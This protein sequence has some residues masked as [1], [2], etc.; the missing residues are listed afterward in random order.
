MKLSPYA[1]ANQSEK[2]LAPVYHLFGAEP[3]IIEEA[4]SELRQCAK[5]AGFLE[6]EKYHVEPGFNW[7][8]LLVSNQALSL[9]ASKKVIEVRMPTGKPGDKGGKAL[10]AYCDSLSPDNVL[11]LISGPIE[12][13]AQN[14]RWFKALD[15][16]GM[17]IEAAEVKGAQIEKWVDHRLRQNGLAFEPN[18]PRVI[19]HFVEGNL[20]AA[21]QQ[22]TQ[23]ALQ[24]QGQTPGQSQGQILDAQSVQKLIA[25]QAHFSSFAYVD[26]C[27][28]GN[29]ARSVRILASLR[30]EQVEPILILWA[31]ARETRKIARLASAK[32][33]GQ[34]VQPLYQR[35]GIWSSRVQLVNRAL[36]RIPPLKWQIIHAGVGRLDRQIKGQ[37]KIDHLDIWEEIEAL[38]LQVCGLK[39]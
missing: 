9:F 37:S 22:I 25:D 38:G 28:A 14:T 15:A 30:R 33:Q 10:M 35:L 24:I 16:I 32:L 5:S 4:L 2:G 19:A 11:I 36:N 34:A 6:R 39:L 1:I 12:K 17:S 21:S 20:L 3:L 27:L 31:L 29:P 7:D 23:L 18:V 8:Q 26:A 13:R